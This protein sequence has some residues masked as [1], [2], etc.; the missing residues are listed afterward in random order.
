MNGGIDPMMRTMMSLNKNKNFPQP[1]S[2]ASKIQ[3]SPSL[4]R[5]SRGSKSTKGFI[6][7]AHIKLRESFGGTEQFPR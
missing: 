7:P 6:G 4:V 5:Q 2:L 3:Y 1:G